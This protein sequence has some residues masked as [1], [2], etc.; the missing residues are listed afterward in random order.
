M[1]VEIDIKQAKIHGVL[2]LDTLVN[3]FSIALKNRKYPHAPVGVIADNSPDWIALDLATQLLGIA[4]IPI[5]HF[6]SHEQKKHLINSAHIYTLFAEQENI[7]ELYGFDENNGQCHGLFL[8][9]LINYEPQDLNKDIQ[10]ITFT[11]GTTSKPKGVC[12]SSEQQWSVA[13]SLEHAL[14]NLKIKKHLCLLPLSVLLENV[15]GVYTSFLSHTEV[16]VFPLKDIGF[17]D[18]F[19]FDAAQCLSKIVE[20]K[21]ESII[22]LPQ[23]LHSI[24][25]IIG[26]NDPR[27]QSLKFVALG[28]A[29]TPRLL[30]QKAKDL[31]LPIY[32]GYGLSEC[33]SVVS[34]NLP[35]ANKVGSVGKPLSNRKIRITEDHE[36]E[37]HMSNKVNYLGEGSDADLWFKTGDIGHIDEEGFLFIDG[38]KKNLIITSYGR[39]ISPEW[40]ESLLMEQ[41]L[42]KQAMV[43]GDAQ[44]YLSAL[45]LPLSNINHECIESSIRS[46]NKD[47]PSYA[48]ILNYIVLDQPFSFANGQLTENGRIKR[49]VI[50]SYYQK[51]INTLYESSKDLTL[52]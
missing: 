44:P 18:P 7:F 33:S 48:S 4:L 38:R 28:G 35:N 8:S 27:I 19:N 26:P 2:S 24:L 17:R 13:K 11:S 49:D 37:I 43:V 40:P 6:F 32:E 29:K 51:E 21:I 52:L 46:V 15:A 3:D 36:I 25:N 9:H 23:M 20:Y 1:T 12:L 14:A 22:L 30:I 50:E 47:L 41:G 45:I 10:K 31:G 16:F 39:N 42:Y 5:P 34:L